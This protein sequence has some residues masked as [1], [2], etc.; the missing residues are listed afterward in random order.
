MP[1]TSFASENKVQTNDSYP[2]LKLDYNE[3]AL[4]VAIEQEPTVE[5]VHTLRAPAVGPDGRV[6]KEVRQNKNKQDYEAV[7]NEFFGAH[8]CFGD[9]DTVDEKGVDPENCPT[10][11]AAVEGEGI[12]APKSR[13]AMHVLKYALQPG[14]W[15]VREPFNL[16]LVAWVFAPGRFNQLVDLATSWNLREHDLKLGPCENKDFQKYD[17]QV[18]PTAEW[19]KDEARQQLAVETYKRN[20]CPDLSTLIGRKIDKTKALEDIARVQERIDQ[21]YGRKVSSAAASAFDTASAAAPAAEPQ[22]APASDPWAGTETS[23]E[24]AAAASV[25]DTPAPQPAKA[26]SFEDIMNDL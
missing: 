1:K 3:R 10:C 15:N 23:S 21:A 4:I 5:Y 11:R 20:Q 13:Y 7:K 12:D 19:A 26:M 22:S 17:I 16:D 8:L 6:I 2:T 14:G 25:A 18:S 9:F 24:A